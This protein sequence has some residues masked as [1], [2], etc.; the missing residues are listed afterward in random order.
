[1]FVVAAQNAVAYQ[2][3]RDGTP[4]VGATDAT[5]LTPEVQAEDAGAQYAVVVDGASGSTHSNAAALHLSADTTGAPP[6]AFWGDIAGLLVAGK[7]MTVAFL[8][9]TNGAYP[10]GQIFW[11]LRG[12]SDTGETIDEFHSIAD[13]PTFD[14]PGIKSSRMFFYIAPTASAATRGSKSYHDFIEYDLARSK[15][16]QKWKFNGDTTRVDAFGLKL[17]IRLQCADGTDLARG[18]DY[19]TF[20]EDRDV[21]FRKYA[22]D[23]PMPYG[24]TATQQ[25]PYRILEPGATANFMAGGANSTY[26]NT[27]VDQVWAANGIDPAIVPKPTGYLKFKDGSHPSLIAALTRHVA[28]QPGTFKSDGTLV[29]PRFWST[30]PDSAFYTAAPA[31]FYARFWHEHSI[32]GK[33]YGFSYDDVGEHSSDIGCESPQRLIVAIGW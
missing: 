19:G 7:A 31:N 8:N 4:I 6:P 9:R 20:L 26:W 21:T 17:A 5:Y 22:A 24:A 23:A 18:E 10:D 15:T 11:Q 28:E 13:R 30:V 12:K 2:W 3:T 25:A 14:S 1:M 32:A 27:Y 33:A 29:N 16:T